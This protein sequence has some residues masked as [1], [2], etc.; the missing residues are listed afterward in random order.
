MDEAAASPPRIQVL[1]G[2]LA[3]VDRVQH[4]VGANG[5]GKTAAGKDSVDF[6][7]LAKYHHQNGTKPIGWWVGKFP[8]LDRTTSRC[9][10][11]EGAE[12]KYEGLPAWNR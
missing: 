6:A 10:S 3:V 1:S 8:F 5:S 9:P 4:L 2:S 7:I 12:N 11:G